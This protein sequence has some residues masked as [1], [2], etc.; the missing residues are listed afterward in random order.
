MS[1]IIN[2]SPTILIVDDLKSNRL[3]LS[4]LLASFEAKIIEANCGKDALKLTEE[5]SNLALVILDVHLPDIDGFEIASLIRKDQKHR[6]VP[7]IFVSGVHNDA[8]HV[9]K[10]YKAGAIDYITKPIVPYILLSKVRIFLELWQLR[11]DLDTARKSAQSAAAAKGRFLSTMSHEIR[12]PMNGVI[13]VAELL[14]H[15]K[16]DNTQKQHV[17]T[18]LTSGELLLTIINDILDIAKLEAGKVDLEHISFNLHRLCDE[19]LVLLKSNIRSNEVEL[20]LDYG[21]IQDQ[22]FYGDP[23][24]IRQ[25]LFNLIGNALKFTEKGLVQLSVTSTKSQSDLCSIHLEVSDTGV[26]IDEQKLKT[27][28]TPF[29]QADASVS[30][31]Y[32]G[33]GLG[34]AICKNL[35]NLMSGNIEATSSPGIGSTFTVTLPLLIASKQTAEQAKAKAAAPLQKFNGHILLAEDTQINQMVAVSMLEKL[36]LSVSVANNGQEAVKL[37]QQK[38]PS[39]VLMDCGMPVMDGYEATRQIRALEQANQHTPILALTADATQEN[40][41]W[42]IESG[43]DE[44]LTKPFSLSILSESLAKWLK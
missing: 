9:L 7:I 40:S 43:M 4:H 22:W 36:G 35:T 39:L 2:T 3:V 41:E 38:P 32:G 16:L 25:V 13:G 27:L 11:H 23:A 33:T 14:S 30:R 20:E 17:D 18:I 31:T 37:F 15:T 6:H 29:T 10:G 34:L 42:C 1:S 26:G 21:C 5:S 28:F 12:T 19:V 44:V 8:E 24:R